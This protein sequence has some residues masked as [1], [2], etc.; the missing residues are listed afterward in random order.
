MYKKYFKRIIDIIIC[1]FCLPFSILIFI[2]IAIMIKIEDG[3]KIFYNAHRI[4]KN[5]LPFIMYKFRSMKMNAPDLRIEDGSTY[6]AKNDIRITKVGKILRET[7]LDETPQLINILFGQMSF[8]GPR[9]DV[10]SSN[11]YPDEYK[12]ILSVLPG[13]TGYNQAHYRNESTWSEKMKNDKYYV[14]HISLSFDVKIIMDTIKIV[15][16]KDKTYRR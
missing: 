14:D 8:I 2:P 12:S 15:K 7:S 4:G 16:N 9:P 11:R 5:G 10:N 3:G 1:I 13:I 6:N